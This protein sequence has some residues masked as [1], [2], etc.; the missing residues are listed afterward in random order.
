MPSINTVGH[1]EYCTGKTDKY[2][3][4][5][6]SNSNASNLFR[7]VSWNVNSWTVNNCEIREQILAYVKPDIVFVL[8]TKLRDDEKIKMSGFTWYGVNRKSQLK[9]AKCGSGG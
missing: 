1:G 2:I 3:L 7:I 5:G 6:K 8:E 9:T 4:E